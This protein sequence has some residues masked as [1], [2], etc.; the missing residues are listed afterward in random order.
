MAYVRESVCSLYKQTSLDTVCNLFFLLLLKCTCV[1]NE[2][3]N[4][5]NEEQ[6][7]MCSICRAS[8][9]YIH[10]HHVLLSKTFSF[11]FVCHLF[12]SLVIF[13]F[14]FSHFLI[15]PSI[16]L[17]EYTWKSSTH[18]QVFYSITTYRSLVSMSCAWFLLNSL[19]SSLSFSFSNILLHLFES[20]PFRNS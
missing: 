9:C 16:I 1:A 13:F 7:E 18:S 11:D 5:K 4:E 6:I 10:T 14:C 2:N 20:V 17:S 3:S 15:S 19:F 12:F 8:T